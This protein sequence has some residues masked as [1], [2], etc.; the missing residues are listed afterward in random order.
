MVIH[1]KAVEIS[2]NDAAQGL[3]KRTF[4]IYIPSE[5]S[6]DIATPL[7]MF[8]LGNE[9]Q[10]SDE[11]ACTQDFSWCKVSEEQEPSKRFLVVQVSL[12]YD[13]LFPSVTFCNHS[14]KYK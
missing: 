8:F 4:G 5:Y 1:L 14:V 11:D 12:K 10:G 9:G 3:V 13:S 6:N 7:V 2:V